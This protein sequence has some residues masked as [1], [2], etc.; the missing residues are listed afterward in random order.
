MMSPSLTPRHTRQTC[1]HWI[2]WALVYVRSAALRR[3]RASRLARYRVQKLKAAA[4]RGWITARRHVVWKLCSASVG[5]SFYRHQV[6]YW[7]RQSR[8]Q[9]SMCYSGHW[10][11]WS[12]RGSSAHPT[13]GTLSLFQFLISCLRRLNATQWKLQNCCCTYSCIWLIGV[14]LAQVSIIDFYWQSS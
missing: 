12:S 8:W 2:D 6:R 7:V 5:T 14:H 10:C 13:P 4:D 1:K 11:R 3:C 9:T